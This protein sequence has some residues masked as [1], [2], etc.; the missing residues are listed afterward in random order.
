MALFQC[1]LFVGS[2]LAAGIAGGNAKDVVQQAVPNG[3][4]PFSIGM[5]ANPLG[6][7]I[8][9]IQKITDDVKKE[10]V[11]EEKVYSNFAC[12]CKDKTKRLEKM[13][14]HH[15]GKI[16]LSSANIADWTARSNELSA[17]KRKRKSDQEQFSSQFV[18]Y[19]R[20]LNQEKANWQNTEATFNNNKG[21]IK[22]ALK[23]MKD[24]K[25]QVSS[26]AFLQAPKSVSKLKQ[27]LEIADAMGLITVPKQKALAASLLQA[28]THGNPMESYDFH[29]GSDDI[30][31]LVESL[32]GQMEVQQGKA[33]KE[34][35]RATASYKDMLDSLDK[36]MKTNK[37]AIHDLDQSASQMKKETAEAREV[38]IYNNEDLADTEA[39]L[40]QITSAC[41]SRADEYA[42]RTAAR[43]EE[44]AA[45][46][47]AMACLTNAHASAKDMQKKYGGSLLQAE[48]LLKL[49]ALPEPSH[50]KDTVVK[51]EDIAKLR[52]R[53]KAA[54][55]KV[56][57]QQAAEKVG[58]QVMAKAV[59][60]AVTEATAKTTVK[61]A[62][63]KAPK[64][65]VAADL[66]AKSNDKL[67]TAVDSK[68]F[69]KVKAA[70]P[71]KSGT[72]AI[73]F[74]QEIHEASSLSN[75][76][77]S[78]DD[79]KK[80]ALAVILSEGRRVKS[81]ML[82]SLATTAQ[83]D[84]FA[85]VKQLISDLRW[86]LE[87]EEHAEVDKQVWCS[88]HLEKT[89][90]ERTTRFEETNFN[91]VQVKRLDASID[92][93]KT[94]IVF[95]TQKAEEIGRAIV[96]IYTDVAQLSAEQTHAMEVQREARD[97]I[98]EAIL[99]LRSYYSHAAKAAKRD[100]ALVQ[101]A[102]PRDP[103]N[104]RSERRDIHSENE[105]RANEEGVREKGRQDRARKR[106]GDLEGG[107]P[108]G[109]RTGSLGDAIALMETIESDFTRE[110]GNLEGDLDEE[111]QE[112]VKT[113]QILLTQKEHA[114]ELRD[115]DTEDLKTTKGNRAIKF[116]DMQTSMNLLDAALKELELLKPTCVDTGMSYS[117]RVKARE[118]E[119]AALRSALCILGETDDKFACP[120]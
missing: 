31:D 59:E 110:I 1:L 68:A 118:T 102:A 43:A 67:G 32:K 18:D 88:E 76:E 56:A 86:R 49:K 28:G 8:D 75:A 65:P 23:S 83:D 106:I 3:V 45:L 24:S 20:R 19:T 38:L 39:V 62:T 90:H 27:V 109:A 95:H 60:K 77:L 42:T 5:S 92:R 119:M 17:N 98:R 89:R 64:T 15:A 12:F 29:G 13:V 34:H 48:P 36:K 46:N 35:V 73:S 87:K 16:D 82:T 113:N 21:L 33:Q 57:V 96:K 40:K 22:Q 70:A 91:S 108:A 120:E 10:A 47:T 79:R 50:A 7:V 71:A 66:L 112:L 51:S 99:T 61:V 74:L 2:V 37:A 107:M 105:R 30:I 114:E 103:E 101:V 111:H 85:K 94:S 52:A 100:R 55:E 115:L 80:K 4:Q 69:D 25:S 26:G 97:E 93:L 116:E 11:D 9:M 81:L 78:A 117:A 84:P 6:K 63:E 58:A 44:L 72:K 14:N 41:T 104:Y 54:G 53:V